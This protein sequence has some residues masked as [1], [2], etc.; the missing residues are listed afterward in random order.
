[1]GNS[2]LSLIKQVS[3]FVI[4]AQMLLHFKPTAQYGKY[5]KL[6]IGVMVLAQMFVPVMAIL[7][8]G[9]EAVFSGRLDYYRSMIAAG[10]ERAGLESVST[11]ERIEEMR[12]EEIKSALNNIE[13]EENETEAEE[14]WAETGAYIRNEE[15]GQQ[16]ETICVERIEVKPDD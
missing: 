7:G 12:M 15:E 11:A 16:Q 9:G 4:C 13:T 1:M 6:L 2:L 10:M 3:I 5:I 8:K 14:D